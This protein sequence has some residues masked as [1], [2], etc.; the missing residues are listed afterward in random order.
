MKAPSNGNN[1]TWIDAV[2]SL[3]PNAKFFPAETYAEA[4]WAEHETRKKPSQ[5]EV[6]AELT[7]LIAEEPMEYLREERNKRLAE[8]DW[9]AGSDLTMTKEQK[10]YRQELRDL[11]STASP[12]LEE[13]RVS[14]IATLTNVT[15]PT[16]P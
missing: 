3:L 8:T 11:P 6:D 15:W 5:E 7:R 14:G 16:K 10:D 13:V 12:E 2:L 4:E 1:Y 9:W